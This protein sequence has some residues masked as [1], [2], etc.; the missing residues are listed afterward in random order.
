MAITAEQFA[1]LPAEVQAT[2]RAGVLMQQLLGNKDT[3]AQAFALAESAQKKINPGYRTS[4]EIAQ[5]FVERAMAEV[6]KKF[7]ERDAAAATREAETRLQ[8]QIA[9]AVSQHGYTEEGIKRVLTTMQ[10]KGVGDFETALKADLMDHPAPSVPPGSSEAMDWNFYSE[11][12]QPNVKAFF[13]GS[14]THSPGL[15]Q[16]EDA[17]ARAAALR[18]LDGSVKLPA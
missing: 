8:A 7:A 5:P 14:A 12:E 3:S 16:D 13:D 6:T 10:E 9:A 17:W 1:S 15:T 11:I 4:E 18:Y 2:L